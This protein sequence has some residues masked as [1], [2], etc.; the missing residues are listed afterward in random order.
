M[1]PSLA[2]QSTIDL[3][4][5][6]EAAVTAFAHHNPGHPFPNI[7]IWVNHDRQR[8]A[9]NLILALKSFIMM[10]GWSVENG[11][12]RFAKCGI[13]DARYNIDMHLWLERADFMGGRHSCFTPDDRHPEPMATLRTLLASCLD[14]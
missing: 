14:H 2:F 4:G 5:D 7:V 8:H 6:M 9:N 13:V 12:M 11:F 1:A 3:V 10:T